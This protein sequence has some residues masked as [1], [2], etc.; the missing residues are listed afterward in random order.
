M[1]QVVKQ[2]MQT[3]QFVSAQAAVRQ[4]VAKEGIRGLYAVRVWAFIV[5]EV[6]MVFSMCVFSIQLLDKFI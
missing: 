3:G 2:R 4:I 6:S 5:V 1:V